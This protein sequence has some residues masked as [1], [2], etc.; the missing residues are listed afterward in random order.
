MDYNSY[1]AIL[2]A[3]ERAAQSKDGPRIHKPIPYMVKWGTAI[4]IVG[5]GAVV[6]SSMLFR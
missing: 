3:Y 6:I 5:T 4:V 2:L 1:M